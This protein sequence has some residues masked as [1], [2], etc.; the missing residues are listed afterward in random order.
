MIYIYAISFYLL[1]VYIPITTKHL[2]KMKS[3]YKS[4]E[5]DPVPT[6]LVK[7]C[8][9]QLLPLLTNITNTS[10]EGSYVPR[11][12][13]CARIRP[14]LKKPGLDPDTLKYYRTVSNLPLFEVVGE[15]C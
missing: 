4:C 13:K 8:L 12:F 1:E 10:M 5:L 7:E 14:F 3:P 9:D 6:W 2:F 11:D 15:G